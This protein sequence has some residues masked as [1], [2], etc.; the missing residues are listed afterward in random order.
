VPPVAVADLLR[1][2]F[3]A[4]SVASDTNASVAVGKT[5]RALQD[6]EIRT[7]KNFRSR[8]CI[9]VNQASAAS[10]ALIKQ[11]DCDGAPT[12]AGMANRRAIPEIESR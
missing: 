12:S 2:V 5:S 10:G 4:V 7:F 8:F 11:F 6:G 9:G 3:A 1:R